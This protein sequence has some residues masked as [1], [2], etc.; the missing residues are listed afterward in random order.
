[1]DIFEACQEVQDLLNTSKENTAREKLIKILDFHNS[2]NLPY[3]P[4][5]NHLIRNVGLYPYLENET[6]DWQDRFIYEA[7]KVDVGQDVPVTLHREQSSILKKLIEGENLAISAPTS[8]GKSFIIDAFIS[9]KNPENVMIIVPTLALTDETRRRLYKRFANKYKIIT[10]TD[11]ELDERNIF[12]FPQERAVHYVDKIDHLD[13]L[14]IDE[15]YKASPKFDKERSPSLL[16]AILKL[17]EIAEQKYFLAPNIS[18]LND[19][20]FTRDMVFQAIDFNT[21]F[22][23]KYEYFSEIKG[24]ENLK[25]EKLLEILDISTGKSLIYAGTYSNIDKVANL[26]IDNHHESES[27]KIKDFVEWLI[28]NYDRNWKLTNLIKRGTGIHT[29][30]LHRSLSQIQ[31]KLFEEEDGLD[32]LV[33]TSSIIEGVNTSAENVILWRNRTGQRKL[34]DFTYKNI[35]GRGGRMFKHFIGKIFILEEPPESTETQLD[36]EFPDELLAEVDEKEYADDLSADQVEKIITY[37]EQLIKLIG[38]SDYKEIKE[39]G[40]FET[41]DSEL[42]L[43]I[44]SSLIEEKNKWKGLGYLNSTNPEDW[45]SSLYKIINLQ[46][47]GWGTE[48]SKFVSFIKVLSSNWNLSIQELLRQLDDY[49]IGIEDF[50]QL[51]RN[52]TY[53]FSAL[54]NDINTIQ[55]V[56]YKDEKVEISSFITKI[57][58]GFL[59]PAVYQLEEYGLPRM[60]AKKI[61]KTGAINLEDSDLSVHSA[62]EKFQEIPLA[63]LLL[64][65]TQYSFQKFDTY[66]LEHFYD[67][68]NAS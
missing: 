65:L 53:K 37:R 42:I 1:M 22:L 52:A 31:I 24:D 38:P 15:F 58:H 3:S 46:P 51:E 55:K 14:I 28:Q 9:M 6:A 10:T 56:L 12:I 34:N 5:V 64:L 8:F 29:G 48:Y 16:K 50:F 26:L 59:P 36:L 66:I 39:A 25:S 43:K 27:E 67:G 33:S 45:D 68:I 41:T 61:H 18:T 32:N 19:S 2:E 44:C 60:L 47:G 21:V 35:I 11:V 40:A 20:L 13:I 30:R 4:L 7:F 49:D 62:I 17:G 54:L 23:E 63:K 57:S